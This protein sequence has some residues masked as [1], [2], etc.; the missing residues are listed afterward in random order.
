MRL[1]LSGLISITLDSDWKHPADESDDVTVEAAERAMEFKLGWYAHPIFV[2][3]T[4]PQVGST[5][6]CFENNEG[7]F[8][9][10]CPFVLFKMREILLNW[11]SLSIVA[12]HTNDRVCRLWVVFLSCIS[13]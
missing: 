4:Y 8:I 5:C 3:G 1:L 13:S 12:C 7:G 6:R 10:F 2:D 11:L 9:I